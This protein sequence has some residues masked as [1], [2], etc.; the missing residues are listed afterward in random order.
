M[1]GLTNGDSYTFTV[2]A[3]NGNGAGAAS[4]ASNAVTPSGG[5]TSNVVFTSPSTATV[6]AGKAVT[7][8][9]TATGTPAPTLTVDP[10]STLPS[11][12]SLTA[13][14]KAGKPMVLS[15]TAPANAG[16]SYTVVLDGTNS[17]GTTKQTL[18]I[19]VLQITSPAT[20]TLPHGVSGSVTVQTAPMAVVPTLTATGVPAGLTFT[21]NGNGTGTLAGT[22]AGPEACAQ[23]LQRAH[24]G[25]GRRQVGQAGAGSD[26]QLTEPIEWVHTGTRQATEGV[27]EGKSGTPSRRARAPRARSSPRSHR[28]VATFKAHD[29]SRPGGHAPSHLRVS[30]S[31]GSDSNGVAPDPARPDGRTMRRNRNRLA[32]LDAAI[33]L[34][35]ENSLL[36]DRDTIAKRSGVSTKSIHRY[37][38]DDDDLL[39]AVIEHAMEVGLPL[40]RIHQI[41]RGSLD[42]RIR[43]FVGRGAAPTRTS[44]GWS[45]RP[46]R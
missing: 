12:L 38:G 7:V 22:P 2:T 3:T 17:T 28:W 10:A 44:G 36:P 5:S 9:V 26:G 19:D 32:V 34:F 37:F 45:G 25:V 43:R 29:V 31:P 13:Q 11:W 16:G 41:G 18:T 46:S 42:V 30:L 23:D 8:K 4:G 24:H 15:G 27:S 39:R 1:T 35:A 21:D 33:G 20:A 40:Y 6:A 14:K